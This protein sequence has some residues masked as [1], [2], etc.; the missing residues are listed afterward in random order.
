MHEWTLSTVSK[1][2]LECSYIR[3]NG[4]FY[5]LQSLTGKCL[6]PRGKIT[7]TQMHPVLLL[8]GKMFY[9]LPADGIEPQCSVPG[10]HFGWLWTSLTVG[11]AHFAANVW[12]GLDWVKM[13]IRMVFFGKIMFIFPQGKGTTLVFQPQFWYFYPWTDNYFDIQLMSI[14]I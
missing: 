10:T 6:Q 12:Q 3:T 14:N 13:K 7:K 1:V 4:K 9:S 11:L 8:N 2:K 5:V